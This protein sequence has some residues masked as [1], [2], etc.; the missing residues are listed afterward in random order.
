VNPCRRAGFPQWKL[1]LN[2]SQALRDSTRCRE[3][4]AKLELRKQRTTLAGR[5]H[6]RRWHAV[7]RDAQEVALYSPNRP[8]SPGY[9]TSLPLLGRGDARWFGMTT[10]SILRTEK[11]NWPRRESNPHEGYPPRDFKSPASAY[12]ATRPCGVAAPRASALA[13]K[14]ATNGAILFQPC[15]ASQE[16]ENFSGIEPDAT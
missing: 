4:R 9:Q 8:T 7:A 12:S 14:V 13:P 3:D 10:H 11:T 15:P 1:W 16:C 6:H 2:V 5:L